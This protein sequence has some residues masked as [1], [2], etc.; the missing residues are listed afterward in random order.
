MTHIESQEAEPGL[1]DIIGAIVEQHGLWRT[2]QALLNRILTISIVGDRANIPDY[3]Q[4]DTGQTPVQMQHPPAI[5][6]LANLPSYRL[7]R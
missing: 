2:L 4:D 5:P 3:L 1:Q 7:R 6:P